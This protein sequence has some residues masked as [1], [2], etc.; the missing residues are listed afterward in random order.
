MLKNLWYQPV[1]LSDGSLL[2][3]ESE[4]RKEE[5]AIL[6]LSHS[7]MSSH[8]DVDMLANMVDHYIGGFAVPSDKG[9]F[10]ITETPLKDYVS[11]GYQLMIILGPDT[12]ES[13]NEIYQYAYDTYS[14]FFW[15]SDDHEYRTWHDES[16]LG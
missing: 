10:E 15:S 8:D 11:R 7:K 13:S 9:L 12:G 14:E 4:P 16:Y 3:I 5:F 6:S 1:N 2:T